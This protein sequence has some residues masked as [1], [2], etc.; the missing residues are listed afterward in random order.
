MLSDKKHAGRFIRGSLNS[1]S[2][3]NRIGELSR[4]ALLPDRLK[5]F[6]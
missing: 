3:M 4:L 6:T 2:V 1:S 5:R